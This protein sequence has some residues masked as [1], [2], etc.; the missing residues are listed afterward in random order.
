MQ[1][2]LY[3]KIPHYLGIEAIKF[4]FQKYPGKIPHIFSKEFIIE[5]LKINPRKQSFLFG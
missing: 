2:G 1:T 3:I 5:S 4:W